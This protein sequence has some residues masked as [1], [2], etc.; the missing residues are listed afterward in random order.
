M[1]NPKGTREETRARKWFQ[2]NGF[3]HADRIP[4]RGA[5][6][7]G[8]L[9]LC[10]GLIAEVKAVKSATGYPTRAV[11]HEWMR[12]TRTETLNAGAD[13]GALIVKRP[14]TQDV[15]RWYGHID[16]EDFLELLN[17]GHDLAPHPAIAGSVVMLPVADLALVLR[18]SGYGAPIT[19]EENS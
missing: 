9:F 5:R 17:V 12:Q 3:P 2:A 15:G 7:E 11:L 18:S 6:D 1:T 19:E 14:G 13:F 8:D 16:T 4:R 10:V